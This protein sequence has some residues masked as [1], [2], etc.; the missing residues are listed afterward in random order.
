MTIFRILT[1]LLMEFLKVCDKLLY[2]MLIF[3]CSVCSICPFTEHL[4]MLHALKH[5]AKNEMFHLCAEALETGDVGPFLDDVLSMLVEDV[6]DFDSL[7][8][9]DECNTELRHRT[10][11]EARIHHAIT[12]HANPKLST[13][14]RRG[15]RALR[16]THPAARNIHRLAP[17]AR[18]LRFNHFTRPPRRRRLQTGCS[19]AELLDGL[20]LKGGYDGTQIFFKLKLDVSKNDVGDLRDILLKPLEVLNET[21]SNFLDELNLFS[22]G[23][24]VMDTVF[25]NIDVDISFLAGAHMA[26]TGKQYPH[27]SRCFNEFMHSFENILFLVKYLVGFELQGDEFIQVPTMSIADI[28][29]R[30]FIQFDDISAKFSATARASGDMDIANIGNIVIDNATIAVAFG[31]GIVEISDKIYFNEIS[32]ALLAMKESAEW[33]QVGAM[34]ITM[35]LLATIEFANGM[36]ISISPIISITSSDLFNTGFPSLNIDLNIE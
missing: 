9:A 18:H 1:N 35:P 29:S 24:S 11:R 20:S 25:D 22:G 3:V 10:L 28:A 19:N 26:A 30:S 17:R 6:L 33:Q 7:S 13:G 15:H 36:D 5:T 12:S 23:T 31:L 2:S 14:D 4:A 16:K 27:V 21:G 32:S 34:D 8:T